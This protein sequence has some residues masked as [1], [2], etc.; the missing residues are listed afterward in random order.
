MLEMYTNIYNRSLKG[1]GIKD[2]RTVTALGFV[3]KNF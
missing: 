1:Q 2:T 3:E